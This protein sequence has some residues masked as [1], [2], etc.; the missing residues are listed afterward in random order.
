[1]CSKSFRMTML[2][3]LAGLPLPLFHL[4]NVHHSSIVLSHYFHRKAGNCSL[5]E[6]FEGESLSGLQTA[7]VSELLASMKVIAQDDTYSLWHTPLGNFWIPKASAH[8]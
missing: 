1:M 2:C 3:L 7:N 6:S 5:I 8:D 4:A